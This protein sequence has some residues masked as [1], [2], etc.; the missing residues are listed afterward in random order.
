MQATTPPTLRKIAPA[1]LKHR[2]CTCRKEKLVSFGPILGRECFPNPPVGETALLGVRNFGM[3]SADRAVG[4][5]LA[6]AYI[7]LSARI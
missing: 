6:P 2:L 3:S 5:T 4:L 7:N 1:P